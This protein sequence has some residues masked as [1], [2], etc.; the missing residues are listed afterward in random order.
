MGKRKTTKEFIVQAKAKF[1]NRFDYSNTVCTN[2]STNVLISCKEHG[3]FELTPA[4][5]IRS[6]QGCPC[7]PLQNLGA[8]PKTVEQ[9]IIDARKKHDDKFDYSRVVYKNNKEDVIIIC[10]KHGL[11]FQSPCEHLKGVYGCR[12]CA[13]KGTKPTQEQF[14]ARAI[15]VHGDRYDYSKTV[16]SLNKDPITIICREHGEFSLYS[17]GNHLSGHGCSDCPKITDV[18]TPDWIKRAQKTHGNRYDYSK[19]EYLGAN[20]NLNIICKSHGPFPQIASHHER[21]SNCPEC[22]NRH[23]YCDKEF[24]SKCKAVHGDKYDYSDTHYHGAKSNITYICPTHGKIT[25]QAYD[26]MVGHGCAHCAGKAKYT[27]EQWIELSREVHEDKYGYSKAD[28]QGKDKKVV[29]TCPKHGDFKQR[30]GSHIRGSG[31]QKCSETGFDS[32]KLGYLYL[33]HSCTPPLDLM[34]VGITNRIIPRLN[35]LRLATPFNFKYSNAILFDNG[36]NALA[37]ETQLKRFA[38]ESGLTIV[39][40]SKFKGYTEWFQYSD[41]FIKQ[42]NFLV[43]ARLSKS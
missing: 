16:Y 19:T 26:H 35:D 18:S 27:T 38:K 13:P 17:A 11:L 15:A 40:N 31:C 39:F 28:Y 6:Q 7:C 20:V 24:I 42:K 21:G 34:K 10:K 36:T 41:D 23:S 9:F 43:T 5:H 32:C 22:V 33:L 12:E 25:Q 2:Q 1:G 8:K 3:E 4:Q 29:I 14:I 37:I 30:A